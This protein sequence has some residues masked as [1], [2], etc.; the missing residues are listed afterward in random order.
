MQRTTDLK[1]IN[2]NSLKFFHS[3]E[4]VIA[5]Y[6]KNKFILGFLSISE[7]GIDF[8]DEEY[9]SFA[10][11]TLKYHCSVRN[12]PL[13]KIEKSIP[14]SKKIINDYSPFR[15][16]VKKDIFDN[17]I[18]KGIFQLG[19]IEQYRTIENKSQRD[20]FEGHSFLN[21]NINNHIVSS[22]C[23]SGFNY[24]IF[25]GTKSENSEE[26]KKQFGDIELNFPNVKTFAETICKIIKAKRYF[27]QNV[28]YNTLKL[29]INKDKITSSKINI[30]QIL[31]PAYFDIIKEHLIYPSLFV[32]PEFFKPENE[33][34]IVFEM[35]KDYFKP[36]RIENKELLKYVK[37]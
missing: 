3:K 26:H 15:K 13:H 12:V 27:I 28:E 16:Y 30:N 17:Y 31:T 32:K 21:L 11:I 7:E 10:E 4:G 8:T 18:S 20:E 37:Y 6:K 14:V 35:T 5:S 2:T 25:C 22:I 9:N 23:N 36:Y 24:L 29:Y 1:F 33:V 34:R 19:T